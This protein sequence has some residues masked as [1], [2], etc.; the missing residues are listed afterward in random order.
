MVILRP[1]LQTAER[2]DELSLRERLNRGDEAAFAEL[3]RDQGGRMLAVARRFL[4]CE[5]DARDAVQ[6]AFCAAFRSIRSFQ[7]ASSLSTWLHRIVVNEC[8]MKLRSASR[9]C[10]E[11]LE[12]LLPT[13][14]ETGHAVTSF[15]PWPDG[16]EDALL[17][18]ERCAAV[19]AAID[20]L[21]DSYR[22]VLLLRDIDDVDT[23]EAARL[24]HL[25]P[26]AVKIQLHRARQALRTLLAPL[27]VPA[28]GPASMLSA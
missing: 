6:G 19:R 4:R 9:R 2:E 14:D 23:R 25:T 3:V 11:S 20:R 12:R 27:F 13:F 17:A 16:A 5:E 1:D 26:N 10:E 15:T 7:G 24:L 28:T 8:L 22:T 21:P 18:K